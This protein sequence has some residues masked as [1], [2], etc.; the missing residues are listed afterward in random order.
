MS[1]PATYGWVRR[2]RFHPLFLWGGCFGGNLVVAAVVAYI[3]PTILVPQQGVVGAVGVIVAF[4][5]LL[6]ITDYFLL[7]LTHPRE[8]RVT[9]AGIEVR[10]AFGAAFVIPA[11]R[12]HLRPI[13]PATFGS[14]GPGG[15]G[16]II[17][18]PD[19]FAA[20]RSAF[21]VEGDRGPVPPPPLP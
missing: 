18:S 13:R 6:P 2:E 1:S 12:L 11:E 20:A 7:N 5:V 4:V 17:L 10:R 21:P 19:Q 9:P 3:V 16:G 14:I 15:E 8:I